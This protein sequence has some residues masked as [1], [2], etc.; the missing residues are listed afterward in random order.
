VALLPRP[1]RGGGPSAEPTNPVAKGPHVARRCASVALW[2][3]KRDRRCQ[4]GPIGARAGQTLPGAERDA[5]LA[6]PETVATWQSAPD[7]DITILGIK[8]LWRR[9]H[10][11]KCSAVGR[12]LRGRV[13]PSSPPTTAPGLG[14]R[15]CP[16][17]LPGSGGTSKGITA[18]GYGKSPAEGLVQGRDQD[19]VGRAGRRRP[20]RL[21]LA[22][23][24][25]AFPAATI[26]AV[27]W[28]ESFSNVF[29]DQG[30]DK[31]N[32]VAD[33]RVHP[34]DET[35]ALLLGRCRCRIGP[36]QS[37]RPVRARQLRPLRPHWELAAG[38]HPRH[39]LAGTCQEGP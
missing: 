13:A 23:K 19:R 2:L 21:F 39:G 26:Y 7:E 11:A 10:S 33:F 25:V 9:T 22:E 27:F 14:T 29:L 15:A 6:E 8:D 31:A 24:I 36:H 1:R 34:S 38:T 35:V 28:G 4:R 17:I 5:R 18:T 3:L 20:L 30:V 37:G 16:F 12:V 32:G